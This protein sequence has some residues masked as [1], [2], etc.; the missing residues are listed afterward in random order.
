MTL[1][2]K[3]PH[4]AL[5]VKVL[6]SWNFSAIFKHILT[7]PGVSKNMAKNFNWNNGTHQYH[8]KRGINQ[9]HKTILEHNMK[10][11]DFVDYAWTWFVPVKGELKGFARN[12]HEKTVFIN[13]NLTRYQPAS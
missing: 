7:P 10:F 13:T 8:P 6:L 2:V 3:D 4:T 9:Y 11:L 1:V 5:Q 12:V